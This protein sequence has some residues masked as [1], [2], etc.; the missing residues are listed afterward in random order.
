MANE[1][2][3]WAEALHNLCGAMATPASSTFAAP[4]IASE[5]PSAV[6]SLISSAESD[7]LLV[8]PDG[9][10]GWSWPNDLTPLMLHAAER[11]QRLRM[12]LGSRP[13]HPFARRVA[14][15]VE[16][17][18]G[19]VH[20]AATPGHP[21]LTIDRRVALLPAPSEFVIVSQPHVVRV[22][23]SFIDGLW[24]CS[25]PLAATRASAESR[26]VQERIVALLAA[27]AKDETVARL[28]GISLRTC[29]RHIADLMTRLGAVSRFQAGA[30]ATR[31]GLVGTIADARITP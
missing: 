18:G 8:E 22:L 30:N 10:T 29:R 7:V 24:A 31:A 16:E 17:A 27:G 4:T 25:A 20:L 12:L 5:V 2:Q 6:R 3:E 19:E 28:L 15:R 21:M 9:S 23:R 26:D 13:S 11:G 1:A 14:Q